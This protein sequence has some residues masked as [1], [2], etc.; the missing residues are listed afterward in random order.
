MVADCEIS[1]GVEDKGIYMT[2]VYVGV[3]I[4]KAGGGLTCGVSPGVALPKLVILLLH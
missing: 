3:I 2:D 4:D 1:L